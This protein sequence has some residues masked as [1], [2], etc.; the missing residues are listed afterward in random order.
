[1]II[2]GEFSLAVFLAPQII[3]EN[4][5]RRSDLGFAAAYGEDNEGKKIKKNSA[6]FDGLEFFKKKRNKR[7]TA[8][9]EK[10]KERENGKAF[11]YLMGTK[12]II[13]KNK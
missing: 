13:K 4:L 7:Q 2:L 12:K 11:Y 3:D 9:E 6:N 1:M 5:L 8:E 10:K